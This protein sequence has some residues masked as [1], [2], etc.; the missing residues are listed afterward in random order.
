MEF[1]GK[2]SIYGKKGYETTDLA[3]FLYGILYDLPDNNG[4]KIETMYT[5]ESVSPL[6]KG[7]IP[8]DFE[9]WIVDQLLKEENSVYKLYKFR[10]NCGESFLAKFVNSSW[11]NP[12]ENYYPDIIDKDFGQEWMNPNMELSV[13]FDF[14]MHKDIIEAL[15]TAVRKY[16]PAT[17]IDLC[18]DC[19]D[20]G[21]PGLLVGA[22]DWSPRKLRVIME[23]LGVLNNIMAPILPQVKG[24]SKRLL[25]ITTPPF[26]VAEIQWTPSGFQI[27]GTEL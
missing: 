11:V 18:E 27:T 17:E 13:E 26:A 12:R 4:F 8:I 25:Y 20:N 1:A 9:D 6:Y 7:I 14:D 21:Y 16:I 2:L 19:W 15:H 22:I 10:Y 3:G 23:F 24:E 5:G